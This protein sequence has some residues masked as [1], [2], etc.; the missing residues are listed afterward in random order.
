VGD[1]ALV[2]LVIVEPGKQLLTVC[3]KGFGKRTA[4]EEYPIKNRGGQGVIGIQVTDRNGRVVGAKCVAETDEFIM[5]TEKGMVVRSAIAD[6]RVIGRKRNCRSRRRRARRRRRRTTPTTLRATTLRTTT[7]SPPKTRTPR[8]DRR[9]AP[10]FFKRTKKPPR[11]TATCPACGERFPAGRLACP[12]CG[13]D[14]ETGWKSG[15]DVDYALADIPE[16]EDGSGD[17][18]SLREALAPLRPTRPDLWSSRQF[19]VFVVGMLL[20]FVMVVPALVMLWRHFR[21]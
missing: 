8:A 13:S 12:E 19:R 21:G 9:S 1:D 3:E 7:P 20:V 15:E 5:I 11:G 18:E 17:D 14:A 10:M 16:P 2:S 4:I 6:V